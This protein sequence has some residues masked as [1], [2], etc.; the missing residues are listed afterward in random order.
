MF[1]VLCEIRCAVRLVD[2]T[3]ALHV[4]VGL[5]SIVGWVT[6]PLEV[7]ALWRL[8]PVEVYHQVSAEEGVGPVV[9]AAYGRV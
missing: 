2:V 5:V 6:P 8:P 4:M 1:E 9:Q 7:P 3:V